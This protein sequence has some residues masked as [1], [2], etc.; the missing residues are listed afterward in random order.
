MKQMMNTSPTSATL[1]ETSSERRS[2]TSATHFA[3]VTLI[4]SP[5]LTIK[6]AL[7]E[8][9][10]QKLVTYRIVRDYRYK[11]RTLWMGSK[12]KVAAQTAEMIQKG[13]EYADA[14]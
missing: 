6:L 3:R 4:D 2:E 9:E 13:I 1:N 14:S 7:A 8:L 5:S 10:A 12:K 11:A